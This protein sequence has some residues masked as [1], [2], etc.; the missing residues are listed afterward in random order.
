M[1]PHYPLFSLFCQLYFFMLHLFLIGAII[2]YWNALEKISMQCRGQCSVHRSCITLFSLCAFVH[3]IFHYATS[4]KATQNI[5]V[6]G[7]TG[8]VCC[9]FT[10]HPNQFGLSIPASDHLYRNKGQALS[11]E[12]HRA[13]LSNVSQLYTLYVKELGITHSWL[14]TY[15]H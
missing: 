9:P 8:T 10:L 13:T 7:R 11:M 12:G 1:H 15:E 4:D 2:P 6:S 3:R 5:T 14:V